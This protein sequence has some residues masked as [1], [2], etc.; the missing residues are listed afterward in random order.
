MT[1]AAIQVAF[2]TAID[3]KTCL[4]RPA[5]ADA[6]MF[7]SHF[8]SQLVHPFV[9]APNFGRYDLGS[10]GIPGRF[11][12]PDRQRPSPGETAGGGDAG[13]QIAQGQ[14]WSSREYRPQ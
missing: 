2:V 4:L 5:L 11:R 9:Q 8:D 7:L 3:T 6:N 14:G 13:N 10:A 1:T 12:G